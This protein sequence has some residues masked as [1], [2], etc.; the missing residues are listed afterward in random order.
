MTHHLL[1]EILFASFFHRVLLHLAFA[2]PRPG[3]P[4]PYPYQ[5]VPLDGF[6]YIVVVGPFLLW[7]PFRNQLR[8]LNPDI[9]QTERLLLH[10]GTGLLDK[11]SLTLLLSRGVGFEI[12]QT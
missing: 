1:F 11:R 12:R 7:F 2:S 4:I 6:P 9:L 8:L 5:I 10:N 3:T